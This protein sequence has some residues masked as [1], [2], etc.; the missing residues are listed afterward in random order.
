[1]PALWNVAEL[2]VYF[3]N[4]V[5]PVTAWSGFLNP[6]TVS[7]R[8]ATMVAEVNTDYRA[9]PETR[10]LIAPPP[11]LSPVLPQCLAYW[12]LVPA[13]LFGCKE[14]EWG[15]SLLGFSLGLEISCSRLDCILIL[16]LP[17][18]FVRS[19]D[20]H[21][22]WCGHYFHLARCWGRMSPNGI[23]FMWRQVTCVQCRKVFLD[24]LG[25]WILLLHVVWDEN[26]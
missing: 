5:S 8:E 2:V 18:G 26:D 13:I 21:C 24:L 14:A 6:F 19:Y 3:S 20:W 23:K 7:A 25:L 11:N 22:N 10:F 15:M 9:V 12:S 17:P 4:C 1:M 16:C